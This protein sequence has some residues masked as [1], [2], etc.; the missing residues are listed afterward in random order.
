MTATATE[1]V[2]ND[3]V[4][5]LTLHNPKIFISSF[6]RP[7][8]SYKVLPKKNSGEQLSA[9][10]KKYQNESVIIY[11]FS[12]NDTDKLTSKLKAAGF[13]AAAYHAGLS[14]EQ[15]TKAQD[16]FIKDKIII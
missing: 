5:Q 8:L 12:R 16:L 3:I 4:A 14:A 9:L 13:K 15:R 2:K 10:L 7:N 6:D 1:K 11:C